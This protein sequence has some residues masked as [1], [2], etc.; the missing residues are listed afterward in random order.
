V[1]LPIFQFLSCRWYFRL[2]IWARLLWQVSR[3]PL[4]L[5]PAHPDRVAG[6][7]FL[8][9]VVAAFA[10]IAVAH[11]ALLCGWL[12]NQIFYFGAELPQFKIE[13]LLMVLTMSALVFVPLMVFAPQLGQAKR[14]A[15]R[16]YDALAQRYVREFDA[17]W[18]RGGAPA[19][20]AFVGSADIQSLADLG[21]SLQ[22]IRDMRTVPI[23]KDSLVFLA[24]AVL[25][26]IAPLVLTMMPL[27]ELL[28]KLFG[29][30]F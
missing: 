21:N 12:S 10:P 27:E 8:S 2:F 29:I 6:L 11:G 23:T 15:R 25:L 22:V 9:S 3:I 14:K 5:I 13:I 20:E 19:D 17:K 4:R 24:L 18:L 26:P 28:K 16:E 30:L 1:S 7:S